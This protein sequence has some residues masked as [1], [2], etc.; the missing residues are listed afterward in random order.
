VNVFESNSKSHGNHGPVRDKDFEDA[1]FY[2]NQAMNDGRFRAEIWP[3]YKSTVHSLTSKGFLVKRGCSFFCPPLICCGNY[4]VYWGDE[5]LNRSPS[6]L[7]TLR[8][9]IKH[10][11]NQEK[12]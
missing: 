11:Y 6:L 9:Y 4:R 1:M 10:L 5:A 2:I 12:P 7:T 3:D 8:K